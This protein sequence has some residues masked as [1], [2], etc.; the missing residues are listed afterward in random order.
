MRVCKVDDFEGLLHKFAL[1]KYQRI[2]RH[3][4]ETKIQRPENPPILVPSSILPP[5]K[6]S[7]HD[8]T[9]CENII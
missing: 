9:H 5:R 6:R 1:S 7:V 3:L 4:S 2:K 8:P